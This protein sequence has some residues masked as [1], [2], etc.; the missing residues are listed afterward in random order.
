MN[1]YHSVKVRVDGMTFDSKKEYRR[2]LDLKMLQRA[3]LISDLRRQVKYEL[4]ETPYDEDGKALFRGASYIADFV[5]VEN[6]KTI[7]E[8]CKGKKTDVYQLKK[9]WFWKD[10]GILI[11]E[12]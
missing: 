4:V 8:D 10:Y 3:G 7:V 2:W 11:R 1:K 6:G 12:T 5:Y 9:K